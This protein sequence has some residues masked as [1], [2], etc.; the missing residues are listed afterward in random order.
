VCS[1]AQNRIHD[2]HL[3]QGQRDGLLALL[4][5]VKNGAV[6]EAIDPLAHSPQRSE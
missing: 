6:S 5:A 4:S 3:T 1:T 2:L